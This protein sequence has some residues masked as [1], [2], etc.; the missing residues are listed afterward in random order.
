MSVSRCG[1]AGGEKEGTEL[2]SVQGCDSPRLELNALSQPGLGTFRVQRSA[3][4]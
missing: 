4:A 3:K 1:A 2:D